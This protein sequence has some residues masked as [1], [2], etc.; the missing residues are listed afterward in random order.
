MEGEEKGK[1]CTFGMINAPS[2]LS[3]YLDL[4]PH[5]FTLTFLSH[6]L[7]QQDLNFYNPLKNRN[8][9]KNIT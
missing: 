4:L 6:I 2:F 8:N 3:R 5:F 9:F 1:A 7:I